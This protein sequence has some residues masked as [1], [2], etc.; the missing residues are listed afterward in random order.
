MPLPSIHQEQGN[1]R[2]D[3]ETAQNRWESDTLSLLDRG[4]HWSKPHGIA[5]TRVRESAVQK[6]KGAQD[7][8]DDANNSHG[9]FGDK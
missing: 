4:T 7:D 1:S 5:S 3:G 2:N 9:Y 6:P 8:Q